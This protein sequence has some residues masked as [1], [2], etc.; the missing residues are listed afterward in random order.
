VEAKCWKAVGVSHLCLTTFNHRTH[1]R[2]P[3]HTMGDNLS[4]LKRDHAA[5]ADAL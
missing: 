5:V 2:I 4:T 3:S 1:K